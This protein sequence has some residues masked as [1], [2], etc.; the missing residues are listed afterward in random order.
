MGIDDGLSAD[1]MPYIIEWAAREENIMPSLRSAQDQG[2][3][4]ER[5]RRAIAALDTMEDA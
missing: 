4:K 2:P 1:D 3:Y 5:I